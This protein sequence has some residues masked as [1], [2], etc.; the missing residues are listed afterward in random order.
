MFRGF[1]ALAVVAHHAGLSTEAFVGAMPAAVSALLGFG[2]LGVDFFFVLSGFIIMYAHFDDERTNTTV[3]RYA[4][5]RLTRIFPAYWPV[6]LGMLALYAAMP[7]L[8]AGGRGDYSLISSLLLVPANGPPALSVAWTLVHE[9]M[10]YG[11]FLLFFV[12]RR[13]LVGALLAW[14][15]MIVVSHQFFTPT[16]WLRYPLSL[17]NIEFMLGVAAA[18]L[19]RSQAFQGQ[20]RAITM[21]G[22]TLACVALWLM[23]PEKGAYFRLLFAVG[24]ALFIVGFAVHE[25]AVAARWPAVLLVLGNVSYSIYLVHNPLLS[26]T[27]RVAGHMALAWPAAMLWGVVLSL[28]AGWIYF[29]MI[30]Q[31]ALR[32]FQS[33]LNVQKKTNICADSQVF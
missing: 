32:F 3:K 10:F 22:G 30:E 15:L 19:V 13:W 8:S 17:L 11:V 16:G 20:G 12:S 24:L 18:W 14:T 9:V 2:L 4:F 26:I 7:G 33:R 25:Q 27:Q 28:V 6:G 21:V 5:K 31:P 29:R 1:A 23:V